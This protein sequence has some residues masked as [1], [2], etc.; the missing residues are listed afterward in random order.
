MSTEFI[1]YGHPMSTCTQRIISIA[2]ER[3]FPIK[4][5]TVDLAKGEHKQPA[6]LAR[7]PFGKV[8]AAEY[9]G[10]SV[11]ESLAIVKW[12]DEIAPGTPLT[13]ATAEL[14]ARQEQWL[15]VANSVVIAE[16][17]KILFQRIWAGYRGLK[18]D[19]AV[20]KSAFDAAQEGF[21]VLESWLSKNEYLVGD[22]YSLAD[23]HLLPYI[24]HLVTLPE[25]TLVTSRPAVSAWWKRASGR[26]SWQAAIKQKT[27]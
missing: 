10:F 26:A 9:K 6:H 12:I 5:V 4:L 15:S 20:V 13:P 22:K 2:A 27:K 24:Q 7:Q 3:N 1:V 18:C 14:R 11:Y 25:A 21:N 23:L 19:D 8:P 16:L 17:A